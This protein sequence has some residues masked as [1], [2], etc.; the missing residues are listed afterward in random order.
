MSIEIKQANNTTTAPVIDDGWVKFMDGGGNQPPHFAEG[1]YYKGKLI[2]AEDVDTHI[3]GPSGHYAR[4][5]F[6]VAGVRL[7]F[8]ATLPSRYIGFADC[9]KLRKALTALNWDGSQSI[10]TLIGR[11]CWCRIG[12]NRRGYEV[13]DDLR[14]QT[15]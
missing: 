12:R 13:I 9:T 4:L 10:P 5:T 14:L 15:T 1:N 8:T 3:G 11:I 7:Q 2:H 6:D